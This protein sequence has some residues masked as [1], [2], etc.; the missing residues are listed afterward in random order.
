MNK[1][2]LGILLGALAG[3]IDVI[4]MVLQNLTWDANLSAFIM[5]VVAGL[6]VSVADFGVKGMLKGVLVAFLVL[7]PSAVLIGWKEP[8]SLVPIS[9]MTLILGAALGCAVGI[10]D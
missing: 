2:T 1:L 7:L 10:W 5:W 6:L 9:A 3:I 8:M 4:P